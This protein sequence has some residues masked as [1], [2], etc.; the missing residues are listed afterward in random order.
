MKI[1]ILDDEAIRHDWFDDVMGSEHE[2]WHVYSFDQFVT[3]IQM[4]E[5]FDVV[6]FDHDLG[7]RYDGNDCAHEMLRLP[8]DRWPSEC[9]V[10]SW[11]PVGVERIMRTLFASGIPTRRRPFAC[12]EGS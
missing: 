9:W 8:V 4:H 11:N 2:I 10:H 5:R 6:S 3:R 1:L 12:K 7:G